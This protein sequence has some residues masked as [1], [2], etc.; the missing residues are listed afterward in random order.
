[1]S[2][3]TSHRSFLVVTSSLQA[4]R[5]D[6]TETRH[7][8]RQGAIGSSPLRRDRRSAIVHVVIGLLA[9]VLLPAF[10][11]ATTHCV[12]PGTGLKNA[13]AEWN[14]MNGGSMTIKLV[15]GT[16]A[17]GNYLFF[18]QQ[19]TTLSMLGGYDTA[20]C[21]SRTLNPVNTVI[22]GLGSGGLYLASQN[23]VTIEGI[24]FTGLKKALTVA[25]DDFEDGSGHAFY[26]RYNIFRDYQA[27][28]TDPNVYGAVDIDGSPDSGGVNVHFQNNLVYN[29]SATNSRPTVNIASR[30][31]GFIAMTSNTIAGIGSATSAAAAVNFYTPGS[32]GASFLENNII[33]NGTNASLDFS[34]G[35]VGPYAGYNLLGSTASN[36]VKGANEFAADFNNN[37]GEPGFFNTSVNDYHLASNAFLTVNT[38]GTSVY[39]P[40]G[41][42][43]HDLDNLD[44]AKR[45]KGSAIDRGAYESAVDDLNNFTVTY[46]TDASHAT[47]PA[48]NCAT[49]S[50]TCTLRQAILDA[51][52]NA[53]A[54]IISFN[55]PCG[56]LLS[57][58]SQLPTIAT[59]VTIDGYTNPG[60]SP[61]TDPN[62]F[63][64]TLCI[65]L[66]GQG[67]VTN[68]LRTSGSGRL[69]VRGLA[70][71]NFSG[72]GIRLDVGSGHLVAGNQIGN[73]FGAN[74]TGV[75][76]TGTS[77]LSTV[78]YSD[79]IASANLISG[80][81]NYGVYID[82]PTGKNTIAGNLIGLNAGG[83]PSA[84][85][86]N[87]IGVVIYNSPGNRLISNSIS[88]N[89][90]SGVLIS[91]AGAQNN[92][93]GFNTIG[94]ATNG[95]AASNGD[96]A[97]LI[98]FAAANNTIGA[99][100][101][102]TDGG[103]AIYSSGKGVWVSPTGAAGNRILANRIATGATS[104]GI[105]LDAAGATPNN[106]SGSANAL[107][108]FP[109]IAHAFRTPTA[110]W[111]ETTID[112][113]PGAA[114]RIDYYW[115][116]SAGPGSPARGVPLDYV[117][118]GTSG[119]TDGSGHAHFW[120]KFAVPSVNNTPLGIGLI[121][122][123][124]TASD[125]S[126]SEI[127]PYV[128]ESTDLIF[129]DELQSG[130][131]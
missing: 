29:V 41:L 3:C 130:G 51:N 70:I 72:S 69:T 23:D 73:A 45:V 63:N 59:N 74:G 79:N 106:S 33:V 56:S 19:G 5:L 15:Q 88:G 75:T 11:S 86:Q 129:R 53:G 131:P 110:E 42:P 119:A 92:I 117:G 90:N 7:T 94:Y 124:A 1:V 107:Q 17:W 22:D 93:V 95:S 76:I 57:V 67:T 43:A 100:Q 108:D 109:V 12:T 31:D 112:S 91:A 9:A 47:A 78:G 125:G 127:G 16:Y 121:S 126:T 60:A 81:T 62:G 14:G 27:D 128:Q 21:T 83:F 104:L 6:T 61:N 123:T 34:A 49:N 89:A 48:V 96:P 98:N 28:G 8:H 85:T 84:A 4:T 10:A 25:F 52:S 30:D 97:V 101:N 2:F 118:R 113:T 116:S 115:G 120:T 35:D 103:N 37:Y 102:G 105:D 24:T 71:G 26:V 64:A 111:I 40:D 68:G 44:G 54:S 99:S 36:L 20:S 58:S 46:T 82:T 122:A 65:Y 80:N 13:L 39:N 66:N 87:G 18:N 50:T 55:L 77:S 32:A 114:F 38:G